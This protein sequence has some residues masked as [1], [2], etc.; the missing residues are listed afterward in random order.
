LHGLTAFISQAVDGSAK[1]ERLTEN[2]A[3]AKKNTV[4]GL[5]K[6]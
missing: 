6:K 4:I 5:N 2:Q 1:H 3:E